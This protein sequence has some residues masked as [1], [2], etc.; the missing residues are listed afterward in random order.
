MSQPKRALFKIVL[1]GDIRKINAESNDA[2]S[3]GGARDIRFS[4]SLFKPVVTKMFP[5]IVR[6]RR[7]KRAGLP[8]RTGQLSY[9]EDDEERQMTIEYWPPTDSRDT[10]GRISRVPDIPSLQASCFPRNEGAV[11]YLLI[12]GDDETLT[13]HFAGERSL[14]TDGDWNP[15]VAET[16]LTALEEAP[17][18][19]S[20]RGWLDW[21]T[22]K[23]FT[24]VKKPKKGGR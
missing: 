8:I 10:E 17:K 2:P 13:A 1:P 16:I 19:V 21:T 6:G 7:T 22:D 14:R 18:N 20:A 5:K 4:H 12:Q 23:R 3:G 11:F 24:T 15:W 9:F